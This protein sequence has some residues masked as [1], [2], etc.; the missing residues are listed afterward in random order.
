MTKTKDGK[1]KDLSTHILMCILLCITI[2]SLLGALIVQAS[3]F[4]NQK[5]QI[6]KLE[7]N[8]LD[9]TM[10]L[11]LSNLHIKLLTKQ[12]QKYQRGFP[13]PPHSI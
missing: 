7:L 11:T 2:V 10:A 4:Y 12:L 13:S 5:S 9:L 1:T 8:R 3:A 6:A